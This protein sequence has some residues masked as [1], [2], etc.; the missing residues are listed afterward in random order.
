MV[1]FSDCTF[2]TNIPLCLSRFK[3]LS[4]MNSEY[5][6]VGAGGGGGVGVV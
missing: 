1:R 2:S 4:E 3:W 6:G 5:R